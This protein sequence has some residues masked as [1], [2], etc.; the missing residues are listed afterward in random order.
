MVEPIMYFGIGFLFASLFGLVLI[1]LVHN[2]AVRLTMKRLEAATPL[3]MAEIQADKDQLRAEFAMSTRRLEMSVEQLKARTTTQLAEIGKKSDA[4][5]RLKLELGE[6][7]ATIFALEARERSLRDQIRTTEQEIS[8]KANTL[9]DAERSLTDRQG[10][11][12]KLTAELGEKAVLT[13]SQRVEIVALRTQ[14]DTLKN[15]VE[16]FDNELKEAEDRLTRERSDADAASREL[17]DER[18]KV[19]NL[20]ARVT[21]LERQLMV[22]TTEA[23][24]LGRRVQDLETRLTEQ[25]RLI[26]ERDYE[27]NQLKAELDAAHK[28][29]ADLRAELATAVSRN[30]ST[31]ESLRAEKTLIESQLELERE[32]RARAQLE[33]QTMKREAETT[34]AAERV[35][36]ALLRERIND[37]AAEVA[38]LT[39]A[40]EGPGSRIDTILAAEAVSGL[41]TGSGLNGRPATNG[42][43]G[44]QKSSLAERIRALQSRS[45]RV[46]STS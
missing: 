31:S 8:V 39:A 40:L 6:K 12:S 10:D 42:D 29:E 24:I 17:S 25:G 44:E 28:I 2:R 9:H 45:A 33:I 21:Q 20:S 38:R 23:E 19:E 34:W 26:V 13:D 22:Q 32:Q 4:I 16:K 46:P 43:Q 30:G 18:S 36:N 3:S 37:I 14:V 41:A 5:N 11:L 1:P 27:T 35:E 15:Q 7:T